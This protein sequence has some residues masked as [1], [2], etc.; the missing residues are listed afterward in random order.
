[1]NA[2]YKFTMA[3]T[4]ITLLFLLTLV[5][6]GLNVGHGQDEKPLPVLLIHGWNNNAGVSKGWIDELK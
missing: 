4:A 5:Q 2:G 6:F 3:A 1:M